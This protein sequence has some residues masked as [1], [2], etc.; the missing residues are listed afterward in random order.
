MKDEKKNR[1]SRDVGYFDFGLCAAKD[2]EFIPEAHCEELR[3]LIVQWA[4][5]RC[6]GRL[7]GFHER[8]DQ[9]IHPATR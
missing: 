9:A 4:G 1:R 3:K 8:G 2:Y 6:R 7:P 5:K